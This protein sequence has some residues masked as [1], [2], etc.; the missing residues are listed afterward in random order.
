MTDTPP[1]LPHD[2]DISKP[3]SD[4][5]GV[6][7][8]ACKRLRQNKRVRRNLPGDGRLRFDR[9]LP[10]LCLYRA[11]SDHSDA[12]TSELVTTE[13]AYVFT[14]GE[15]KHTAGLRRLCQ[16]LDDT[17]REHFG[18]FLFVEIWSLSSDPDSDETIDTSTR[19]EFE[20][21]ATEPEVMP[22]TIEAFKSALEDIS[23]HG[24]S[25]QVRVRSVE[26]IVPPGLPPLELITPERNAAGCCELGLAVK[27]I[28]RDPR[29]GTLY[30]MLLQTLRAELS[31]ALRKTIVSF[32]GGDGNSKPTH[33]ESL[34]PSSMVKAARLVDQQ[35]SEVAEAFDFVLQA[36]P[37][38]AEVAWRDFHEDSF[39]HPPTFLY[40][41]LPYHP[42][43]LKRR[44]F[45]IEI[46]RIED[47]TLGHLFWEK[48]AEI[49]R[50]LTALNDLNTPNFLFSSHQLYG[51]PDEELIALARAVL[52]TVPRKLTRL[53][54]LSDDD[55]PLEECLDPPEIIDLARDEIDFY[56]QQMPEFNAT[57]ELSDTIAA[58]I[59][60]SRGKL[61]ISSTLRL[62]PDRV[63]PLL[64]HEIGTHLVTYFNGRCQPFR[65]LYAGL[66]GYEELQE[67]LAVLAEYLCGGLSASRSRTLAGRV[68]AVASVAAGTSFLD[69]FQQ[70]RDDFGFRARQSFIMSMRAH[71]GGGL[72]KDIIYLRGLRDL[73]KYLAGGHDLEPLYVGKFGLPHLPYIQE[74]RRRGII[75]PPKLLP[76]FWNNGK[77]RERLE[78]CRGRTVLELL[79]QQS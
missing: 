32:T 9:Q 41:P 63:E 18:T 38:N 39:R 64:H 71:R 69:T 68:M 7:R 24:Q 33:F 66:A 55:C 27:P 62:R 37:I 30:P 21:V 48:Q 60:V 6:A 79:E 26:T 11:P 1:H 25:A 17:M 44:L 45:G 42:R 57:V 19:P 43:L 22:S 15:R 50:Q 61:L 5:D 29:H 75:R 3:P 54:S 47:P 8:A 23:I 73:L 53:D 59:M 77:L 16:S 40:R 46:E 49:D 78:A 13:A 52:A 10:F 36:T 58:G 31:S 72:T 65:Q 67:G 76:R 56:H 74:L 70:L 20:I 12:G 2:T 4:F 35:L 34:G 14:S 28:Y 51:A